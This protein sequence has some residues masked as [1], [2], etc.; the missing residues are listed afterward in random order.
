MPVFGMAILGWAEGS[1]GVEQVQ[2][3]C[4]SIEGYEDDEA[5]APGKY[6][7]LDRLEEAVLR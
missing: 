5:S 6:L 7:S 1:K 2:R 3:E 4:E